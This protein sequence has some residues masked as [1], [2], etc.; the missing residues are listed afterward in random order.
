MFDELQGEVAYWNGASYGFIK[1][2]KGGGDVFF[3][4]TELAPEHR[5]KKGDPLYTIATNYNTSISS[6]RDW[7]NLSENGGIRI[8]ERLTIYVHR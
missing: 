4:I 5:V 3:H 8:G 1:P 6:I 2:D 7:N